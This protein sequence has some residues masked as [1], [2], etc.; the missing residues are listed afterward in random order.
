M[1][2]LL[3]FGALAFA[4]MTVIGVLVA[5]ASF[6]G[7]VIALPFRIIGWSLRLLGLLIALPFMLLAGV[8]GVG[9]LLLP[10]APVIALVWLA[11]WLLRDRKPQ[12]SQATVVS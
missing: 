12:R 9:A 1:I 3:V 7:F 6:M 5:V 8:L 10:L 2:E 11:W 4:A